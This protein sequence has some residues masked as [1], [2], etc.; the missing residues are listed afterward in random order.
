MVDVLFPAQAFEVTSG[1]PKVFGHVS[2]GSGKT[3]DVHF[4]EACGGRTH[5]TFDAI[6]GMVGVYA[7]TFDDVDWFDPARASYIFAA[8]A[9]P[10]TVFPI[11]ADVYEN[12]FVNSDGS[13]ATPVSR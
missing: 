10:G 8:S 7:G 9:P 4:C 3:V 12:G 6:P 2:E 5:L 11:T 1:K 13:R